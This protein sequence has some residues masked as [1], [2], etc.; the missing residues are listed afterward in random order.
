MKYILPTLLLLLALPLQAEI[1]ETGFIDFSYCG[2]HASEDSIPLA[3]VKAYVECAEG[4]M[5]ATIQQA[6]DYVSSLPI[7]R[8]GLRGAVLLG[9]GT[10]VLQERLAIE[11]SGVVLRGSGR[12]I[13]VL[14]KEG[15]DRGSLLRIEGRQNKTYGK[16]TLWVNEVVELGTKE[17]SV[18]GTKGVGIGSLANRQ[19]EI[20]RQSSAPWIEKVGCRIYGG[21][22]DA[23]AWKPGDIDLLWRRTVVGVDGNTLKL[24]APLTMGFDPNEEASYIDNKKKLHEHV[25]MSPCYVRIV[26]DLGEIGESGI[27]NLSLESGFDPRNAHDENHC[28]TGVSLEYA[29]DCWVRLVNFKHLAGA[30]VVMQSSAR[31]IT[32]EDCQYLEP[33]SENAGLRRT[34]FYVMGQQCLVQRCYAR[35]GR[36]DFVTGFCAAG[37]NAFVQCEAQE[38]LSY[39]GGLDSWACGTLYDIVEI[40]GHDLVMKNLGQDNNGAGWNAASSVAWQCSAAE[41]HCYSPDTINTNRAYG[42]WAQFSG[43]GYWSN[44][45]N[46]VQPRSLYYAQLEERL[47]EKMVVNPRILMRSTEASSSPSVA[48]AM[49]MAM[50]ARNVPRQTLREWIEEAPE[51]LA[52][53]GESLK[54]LKGSKGSKGCDGIATNGTR[55]RGVK[56]G[57]IE[58]S[59]G[60]L[61]QQ[62]EILLGG[63]YQ[64]P[65]WNGKLRTSYLNSNACK[66]AL[67][68][69]VPDR[70]GTGLTDRIDSVVA[71]M[72]REDIL[73]W[74]QNY[75]L[76]YDRRRDDHERIRRRDAAVWAPFWEQP[77]A[78]TGQG[79]AWNRLSLYD[80]TQNNTWYYDRLHR[81][82][83]QAAP[84]GKLLYLEHYFQHNILEAGAHWVDSPWRPTNNVNETVFPEPVPFTGD[85]RI[86]VAEWFYDEQN[87]HMADLHRQYIRRNLEAF[88]DLNNVIHYIS[89]EY[90]GPL[91]F[92]RFW[93][94]T[95]RDWEQ[96][97][98]NHVLVALA[99]TKDVQDSILNDPALA[100]TIDIIDI[101]YWHYKTRGGG[102]GRGLKDDGK[103]VYDP[104]GGL[105]LAPRQ[106][107][108]VQPVG[109][110]GFND[111][112]RAVQE[113]RQ[114]YPEKAVVYYAQNYPEQ[115]WA[116]M[117]AGGSGAGVKIADANL[118]R[119]L[120]TMQVEG[121]A[122]REDAKVLQSDNAA[123]VYG[124]SDGTVQ[125]TNL[126]PGTYLLNEI[127][128]Q[129]GQALGKP[130]RLN[131]KS[132]TCTLTIAPNRLWWVR[133]K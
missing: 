67:T 85:K 71:W 42:A 18:T 33:V 53:A 6:I 48:K 111:V 95:I 107:A 4:D 104:Q 75:G 5:S 39:S 86:F 26:D 7:G 89:E 41:I 109:K 124:L 74:D 19:V 78:N 72:E 77:W 57:C 54:G 43:D 81:F 115:A 59:N 130:Q 110:V 46:H 105:N 102:G 133:R 61:T 40:D 35:Q 30:G 80:L 112:Y 29:H 32:V 118:R 92:T 117:M 65:W 17:I 83:E 119:Q 10:F 56:K 23:L 113:Y 125:L 37:P 120:P 126:T 122:D 13:T 88:K 91:H 34:S 14:R 20:V 66:P 100:P 98:G 21:G 106:H 55:A 64:T 62:G 60:R 128:R 49:E 82:A 68:R 97:T 101:R 79:E 116:I 44:S 25:P 9:P 99:A 45:N 96:E 36:H 73:A 129:T 93:V 94:E 123:L 50:E 38:A 121:A 27:E 63:R 127:D 69:F 22:I 28:W 114:H 51:L 15:F 2:Y 31:R 87:A 3:E 8:D 16:D 103:D 108:R 58:I 52:E 1:K 47:G 84:L 11:A 24:D 70:E 132:G 76:W 90:T 12:D 131:V